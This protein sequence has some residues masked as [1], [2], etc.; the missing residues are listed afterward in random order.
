M[1][2]QSLPSTI[3]TPLPL[4]F[5]L[6]HQ[7]IHLLQRQIL[8]ELRPNHHHRSRAAGAEA[9]DGFEGELAIGCGLAFF[10]AEFL[11]QVLHDVVRTQQPARAGVADLDEAFSHGFEVEHRVKRG[12]FVHLNGFDVEQRGHVVHHR[13]AQ[14]AVKLGLCQVQHGDECRFL[15]ASRVAADGFLNQRQGL[16]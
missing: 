10:D 13:G 1:I 2:N 6:L 3:P 9:F 5:P 12:H 8:V 11:F 4:P 16:F 15:A 14:P 7:R